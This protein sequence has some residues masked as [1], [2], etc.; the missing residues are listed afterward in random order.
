MMMKRPEF[1]LMMLAADVIALS[2]AAFSSFQ[3]AGIPAVSAESDDQY[4]SGSGSSSSSQQMVTQTVTTYVTKQVPVM[5]VV[6]PA[7]YAT[8][9]DGDGL[10]DAVDPDPKVPQQA[11]F[12]DDDGDGVPNLFDKHPGEDDFAYIDA[13]ADTNG[14]IGALLV[15]GSA[16][17]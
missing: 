7:E 15:S 9:T 16:T 1:F 10:V 13:T 12:T 8:D 3:I 14:I 2:G 6:T 4:E 5:S 11:Y 17:R